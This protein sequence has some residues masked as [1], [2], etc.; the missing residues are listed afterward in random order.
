MVFKRI[1]LLVLTLLLVCSAGMALTPEAAELCLERG[2]SSRIFPD[3]T[4]ADEL[5][6]ETYTISAFGMPYTVWVVTVKEQ[7]PDVEFGWISF[8]EP[9]HAVLQSSRTRRSYEEAVHMFAWEQVYGCSYFWPSEL[10]ARYYHELRGDES[11]FTIPNE[12]EIAEE[13]AVL[14]ARQTLMT[15]AGLSESQLDELAV[16]AEFYQDDTLGDSVHSSRWWGITFRANDASL[17]FTP[18]YAVVIDGLSG[19]PEYS[20]DYRKDLIV[21]HTK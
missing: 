11:R 13:E 12:K 9:S 6:T 15:D 3:G 8:H 19:I 17:R 21:E 7:R 5:M 2:K 16:S 14:I 20:I 4:T 10:K 18:L 1:F